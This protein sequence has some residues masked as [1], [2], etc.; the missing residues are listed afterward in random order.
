MVEFIEETHQ[1]LIDGILVPS[2]TQIVEKIFPDKYKGVPDYILKA[3][4]E[5]GIQ[6]HK[7]IEIIEIKKPKRPI[8][9]LKKYYGMNFIQEESIKQYLEIKRQFNIEVLEVE[10]IVFYKNL[11]CGKLDIKAKVNGKKAIIDVKAT[12]EIDKDY[13]SWQNSYYELADGPVEELYCLW[14]PKGHLGGLFQV[15][16][17]EEKEL[18]EVVYEKFY[19]NC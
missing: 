14:L 12:S 3:K 1:Y 6:I 10:K 8:A 7:F 13:V 15:K 18:L 2:V 16:R 5:Y 11:Y 17:I 19:R 9:Y 4:A